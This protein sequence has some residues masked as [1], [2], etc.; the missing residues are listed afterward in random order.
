MTVAIGEASA[1]GGASEPGCPKCGTPRKQAAAACSRCG[2]A[3]ERMAEFARS[4]D[5]ETPLAVRDA[6]QRVIERWDDPAAHEALLAVVVQDG[7]YAWA[8]ARYREQ[9]RARP[10][11]PI[12]ANRLERIRRGAEASMLVTATRKDVPAGKL[13]SRIILAILV[14]MLVVGIIVAMKLRGRT[15]A[16]PSGVNLTPQGPQPSGLRVPPAPETAPAR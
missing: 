7:C 11:D 8:A 10:D 2:L 3:A 6:W 15:A 5:G 12:A 4:K 1:A 13:L 16:P 14:A 9:Q